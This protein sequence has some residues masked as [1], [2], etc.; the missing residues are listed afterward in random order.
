AKYLASYS[1]VDTVFNDRSI[2]V[3]H[4]DSVARVS[5]DFS[6]PRCWLRAPLD[7][8]VFEALRLYPST[9]SPPFADLSVRRW[10]GSWELEALEEAIE[11]RVASSVRSHREASGFT[12]VFH[13]HIAQLLQVALANCELE[14]VWGTSQA[15]VFESLAKRVCGAGEVLRAV[16]VQFN[17]LKVSL[18]WPAL[19]DKTAVREVL[20]APP[21]T[22][23]AVR[24][25]VVQYPE[26][27]VAAWVL[28]AAKGRI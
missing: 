24:A 27:A 9:V 15:C 4:V 3:C 16:P 18:F 23:F 5:Y 6:D 22:A 8:E 14:R 1:S 7:S 12:T 26:G 21:A 10:P 17:H 19:S 28:L 2:L 13:S 20:A 11:Q 25:K